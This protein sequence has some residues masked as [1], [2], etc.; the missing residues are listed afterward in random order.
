MMT[1]EPRRIELLPVVP[2][3]KE[4]E[5]NKPTRT[6]RLKLTL[7]ESCDTTC[8]EFSYTELVKNATVS[9]RKCLKFTV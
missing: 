5:K 9:V 4:K 2:Q 3:E 1:G 8:P 7:T 6:V